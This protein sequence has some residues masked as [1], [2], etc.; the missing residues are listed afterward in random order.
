MGSSRNKYVVLDPM[1]IVAKGEMGSSRNKCGRSEMNCSKGGNGDKPQCT[2]I[3]AFQAPIV[4]KGEM[5][6]SRNWFQLSAWNQRCYIV[7][8]GEMGS[9]RNYGAKGEM[10]SSFHS[11]MA[12]RYNCSK[13]GNGV[14]PQ[15]GLS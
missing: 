3:M 1:S 2:S 9:S 12:T 4:A 7:A 10:G 8:K 14:K 15:P 5:G 11:D 13:G 6:S